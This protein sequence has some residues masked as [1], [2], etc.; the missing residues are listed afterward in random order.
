MNNKIK[1]QNRE[2][3]EKRTKSSKE[4]RR[5]KGLPVSDD[6]GEAPFCVCGCGQ[7]V[8]KHPEKACWYKYAT[9]I[10]D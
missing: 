3:A 9:I 8:H 1:K 4:T 6:L 10:K 2:W 7:K 5:K